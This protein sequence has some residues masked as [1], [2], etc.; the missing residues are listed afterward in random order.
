ML[1]DISLNHAVFKGDHVE[2]VARALA[3][4][5]NIGIKCVLRCLYVDRRSLRLVTQIVRDL[6]DGSGAF[7]TLGVNAMDSA[8]PQPNKSARSGKVLPDSLC[9]IC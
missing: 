2:F 7:E 6:D 8:G 3:P 5:P 4:D 9:M 1:C